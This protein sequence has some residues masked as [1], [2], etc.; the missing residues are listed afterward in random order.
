MQFT[1]I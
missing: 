1:M